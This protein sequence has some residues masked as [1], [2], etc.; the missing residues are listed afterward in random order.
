MRSRRGSAGVFVSAAVIFCGW[1]LTAQQPAQT[2]ASRP[3]TES[4]AKRSATPSESQK[5]STEGTAQ[6]AG[7]QSP[8][9]E[10]AE[11]SKEAAGEHE[12]NAEFKQSASV[13]WLARH[14]GMSTKTASWVF[15]LI[16][17][18][19][20]AGLI[21]ML[22]KSKLPG[23]FRSQTEIIQQSLEEARH[24]S[25]EA[26]SRLTEIEA[27]L[28]RIDAEISEMRASAESEAKVEEQRILAAAEAD[29]Q[30]IIAAAEQEIA[31]AARLAR[32]DL[33]QYAAELA[34]DVAEHRIQVDAQTDR[35][36]VRNF[37]SQFG[38]DG[39]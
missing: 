11:A 33:K 3:A 24:S 20:I 35:A 1:S 6:R 27:R 17:F 38:K 32:R 18:G 37:A 2:P 8:E 15:F 5:P 39:Q 14:T 4:A 29:K 23:W 7:E 34:V 21:V 19:I 9:Q 12:E 31:A 36:L 13:R 30:H 22:M 28:A 26:R 16:N 25:E 10:I